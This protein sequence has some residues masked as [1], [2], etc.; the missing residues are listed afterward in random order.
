MITFLVSDVV[1]VERAWDRVVALHQHC[2]NESKR[3][4]SFGWTDAGRGEG[5]GEGKGPYQTSKTCP[6]HVL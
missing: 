1:G 6:K 5:E 3:R 2:A 4:S